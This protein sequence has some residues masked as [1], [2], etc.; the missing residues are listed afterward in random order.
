[1]IK[2]LKIILVDDNI[3]FRKAII[4]LLVEQYNAQIIGEAGNA[5]EFWAINNYY[6]ADIILMDVM[7]PNVNG[8]ELTKK[9][10][11]QFR[12]IKIIAITMHVD[13]V[14]LISLIEAGFVGCIFKNDL[15]KSLKETID[16]VIQ[17]GRY[18]PGNILIDNGNKVV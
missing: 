9:I 12:Q 1:M 15:V 17:G 6:K 14:Y 5:D 8:I 3:S 16:Y 4:S 18:F 2:D 13:K 11:W 7:I 10:L